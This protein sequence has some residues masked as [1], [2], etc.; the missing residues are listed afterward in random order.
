MTRIYY[1]TYVYSTEKHAMPKFENRSWVKT[2]R[3]DKWKRYDIAPPEKQPRKGG[4]WLIAALGLG[5]AVFMFYGMTAIDDKHGNPP[6]GE[7]WEVAR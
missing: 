6:A 3:D 5:L 2:V 4:M 7:R 1:A